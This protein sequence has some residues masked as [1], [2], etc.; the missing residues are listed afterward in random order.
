MS[1]QTSD[2]TDEQIFRALDKLGVTPEQA[3][4]WLRGYREAYKNVLAAVQDERDAALLG[5]EIAYKREPTQAEGDA[6][7][8]SEPA[9][10]KGEC[11]I[12]TGGWTGRRCRVCSRWTWG[13]PTACASCVEIETLRTELGKQD[14]D[15]LRHAGYYD[16]AC[17]QCV[18]D[19]PSLIEGFACGYHRALARAK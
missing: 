15:L 13:G 2:Y 12:A 16:H 17:K 7:E 10:E 19:G 1:R 18:P 14:N 5:C 9:H 11:F 3:E 4:A 6:C 8:R